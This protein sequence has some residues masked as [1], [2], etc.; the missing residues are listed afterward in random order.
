MY[1]DIGN[2]SHVVAF[3]GI[4]QQQ[5]NGSACWFWTAEDECLEPEARV[6]L[7]YMSLFSTWQKGKQN[8]SKKVWK[9]QLSAAI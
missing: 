8:P 1:E 2:V 9:K 4:L 5:M 7:L 3:L 6:S